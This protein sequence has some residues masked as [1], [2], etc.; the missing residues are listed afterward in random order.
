MWKLSNPRHQVL[1]YVRGTRAEAR[2]AAGR[3]ADRTQQGVLVNPQRAPVVGEIWR[4]LRGD[5]CRIVKVAG[6]QVT[7]LQLDTG[8]RVTSHLA[9]FLATYQPPRS[10]PSTSVGNR[11]PRA[12]TKGRNPA[13][14]HRFKTGDRFRLVMHYTTFERHEHQKGEGGTVTLGTGS[15]RGG[16]YGVFDSTP[17][18]HPEFISESAVE[19]ESKRNPSRSKAARRGRTAKRR[20]YGSSRARRAADA[21][22]RAIRAGGSGKSELARFGRIHARQRPNPKGHDPALDEAVRRIRAGLKRR[23]GITWSVTRGTGSVYGWIYIRS[24]R[25]DMT[26]D[27]QRFLAKLLGLETVHHQGVMIPSGS[28]ERAEYVARAEGKRPN[29][30][31]R[32]PNAGRGKARRRTG[33]TNPRSALAGARRMAKL[34]HDSPLWR[35]RGTRVSVPP[36]PRALAKLG[37][38]KAVVYESDKYAGTPDNP[39]GKKQLYEHKT[40][41][42]HP[43]LAADSSGHIHIVG[44]KMVPT[45][46]GLIN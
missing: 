37:E 23:G 43:V 18:V 9:D 12:N 3:L 36:R 32:G 31:P 33:R 2:A 7:V 25:G 4:G 34:W 20:A 5:R 11:R 24:P 41:R 19:R 6:T 17:Y 30:R 26:L 46:D 42:P 38:L 44:G 35:A 27:E 22:A 16:F 45:A 15:A 1:G 28:R 40:K 29:R 14:R 39:K 13:P 8:H 21:R 10:V